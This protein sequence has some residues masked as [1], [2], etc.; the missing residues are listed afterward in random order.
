MKKALLVFLL[1][2]VLLPVKAN[3]EVLYYGAEDAGLVQDLSSVTELPSRAEA[4]SAALKDDTG[5]ALI[6]QQDLIESIQGYTDWDVSEDLSIVKVLAQSDLYLVC[7]ADTAKETGVVDLPSLAAYLETHEYELQIMRSFQA[8]NTD[9]ASVLLLDELLLDEEMF[10]DEE[11]KWDSIKDGSYILAADTAKAVE[12]EKEGN[13]VLGALT[14]ERT[15]EYPD[16]ACAGECGLPVVN[17]TFFMLATKKDADGKTWAEMSL[18]EEA[19]TSEHLH[20]ADEK[21][22]VEEAIENY[23]DYMTEEGLFFY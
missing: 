3:A 20:Q 8:T 5:A 11:N 23:V 17:G 9:Y 7:S 4:M 19:L 10:V 15:A 13:V 12:L 2:T 6:T 1:M 16:L 22:S 21:L 18:T 14:K